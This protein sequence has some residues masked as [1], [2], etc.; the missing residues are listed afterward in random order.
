MTTEAPNAECRELSAAELDG[1][2][3]GTSAL[4][5]AVAHAAEKF[6]YTHACINVKGKGSDCPIN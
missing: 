2:S 4:M 1:V 3:G 6:W 5:H